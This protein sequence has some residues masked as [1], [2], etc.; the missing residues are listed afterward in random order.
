MRGL[1]H[2]VTHNV[3]RCGLTCA[4]SRAAFGGAAHALDVRGSLAYWFPKIRK[5]AKQ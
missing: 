1:N 2:L 4:W 5:E 3:G